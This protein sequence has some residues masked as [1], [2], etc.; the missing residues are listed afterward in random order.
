MITSQK[1]TNKLKSEENP[2][3]TSS[4]KLQD[5]KL[6][7]ST[8]NISTTR[9]F[10]QK[11]S[12]ADVYGQK[13]NAHG[14]KS[15][16]KVGN[17]NVSTAAPIKDYLKSSPSSVSQATYDKTPRFKKEVKPQALDSDRRTSKSTPRNVPFSNVT[18]NSPV[19][20]KKL[21]L[22]R[23]PVN[24][25]KK[26]DSSQ[27]SK[28][29]KTDKNVT[30]EVHKVQLK[31][32]TVENNKIDTRE[33]TQTRTLTNDEVRML[34]PTVVDNNAQMINLTK[35]LKAKPKAFYVELDDKHKKVL[36]KD[37][38]SEEEYSYEDDFESYE[39]DFDSYYSDGSK[40]STGETSNEEEHSNE[41]K[42]FGN[43]AKEIKDEEKMLDSGSYDLRDQRSAN[44]RP[45][46]MEFIL[47][48]SEDVENKK[49]SL[50]DEGFLEMSSSSAVLNMKH[51]DML[52]KPLF[53]DFSKSKQNKSKK[54][55]N[56]QLKQRAKD[57][58]SM[59]ILHKMS[60]TL[61]EMKPIPY[62]LYMATFGRSNYTQIAIQTFDD[63]ITEEVQTDE[64]SLDNKWTQYPVK[65]SSCDVYLNNNDNKQK[66]VK[67]D[68]DYLSKFTLLINRKSDI[69]INDQI[70]Q[71][72]DYI[73]NPLRIYLEQK[74]GVGSDQ[75]LPFE[76]Y[77]SKLENNNYNVNKLRK[78]LKKSERRIF[79]ILNLNTGQN[80][81]AL[82]Q[83]THLP[84]S[85]G[86][87]SVTLENLPDKN[88]LKNTNIKSII[89]S[90]TKSNLILTVH[91]KCSNGIMAGKCIICLWDLSVA[92]LEPHKILIA[93]DN[94]AIGRYRGDTNGIFVAAL[95]DGSLHL[96]DLSE[97]PTW[98]GD[99]AS[100]EKN[101]KLVEV[102][103]NRLTQI[104]ID[105][106]W[107]L[108]NSHIGL[109][110]TTLDCFLLSCAYTSSATNIN[111][112]NVIDNTVGL[113]FVRETAINQDGERKII[114][115]ICSLQKLGIL[116]IWSIVQEKSKSLDIGKA[117]WSKT[118]LEKT[119]TI[120]LM[121]H[122]E[123]IVNDIDR[124][125]VNF[126]LNAAKKRLSNRKFIEKSFKI[127]RQKH[128][129]TERPTSTA[130]L[131]K[132]FSTESNVF[133]WENGILCCDLKIAVLDK[134][135]IYLVAK[136]CGEV[137]CCIRNVGGVK[138]RRVCVATDTSS[139]SCLA[140]SSHGLPYFLAATDT[141][142]VNLCS[143]I[144]AKV[145]LTL[146]C[147][148]SP[149]SDVTDKCTSDSKGRYVSSKS[150]CWSS[151]PHNVADRVDSKCSISSLHWPHHNPCS[152]TCL[153]RSN[154][155]CVWDLT[156]SDI[157][158]RYVTSNAA[159][160]CAD[161][162]CS[163]ALLTPEGEV[164]VHRLAAEQKTN[165]PYLDL[166][167]KYVS[168]LNN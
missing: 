140:V 101:K 24:V 8:S 75:M 63:G 135:E 125:R 69:E 39:S 43:G 116:T 102:N 91:T 72:Q 16:K 30:R 97:E 31:S 158:A 37:K 62:D 162:D 15:S 113:E 122:I 143:L 1:K 10:V 137:L 119:Q 38:S 82:S 157:C 76:I 90:E 32:K 21:N 104:E 163:L 52:E 159:T 50:T 105:R 33:R 26:I 131:K 126:N 70:S 164:Q 120:F 65:F 54:R 98:R 9:S 64:I 35:T 57:L 27:D 114:G 115:Q 100:A 88:I 89:F 3:P 4:K 67:N 95:D 18:V 2:I 141:G 40:V 25:F 128:S 94:V 12:A 84:F 165:A 107:N 66:C 68:E 167:Q 80:I 17:T 71:N 45:T 139:I 83:N 56:E 144:D 48:A 156:H 28:P 123:P 5:E 87:T 42:K 77:K 34:T 11:S 22:N 44:R 124:N 58:L 6:K 86:S 14:A 41:E 103:S 78:F 166:F 154:T 151:H 55:L 152:I 109:E 111:Y 129:E 168:L 132:V 136:N 134:K 47:E 36:K 96:W 20:K 147:L 7:K 81:V 19:V 79:N 46:Q 85:K 149:S 51:V 150:V 92:R 49:T 148:N 155:L 117:Y 13:R 73:Q 106:E 161:A 53:I 108:K 153:L 112:N 145:L 127:S 99:D 74:D 138:V 133:N 121:D 160:S 23:D 93:I 61:F 142:T 29:K 146:D 118:K 130:S 60:Y 110:E 59:I